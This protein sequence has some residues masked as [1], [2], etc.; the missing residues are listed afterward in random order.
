[1][2]PG[3]ERDDDWV[4]IPDDTKRFQNTHLPLGQILF[5]QST[6][7]DN[8]RNG[9]KLS[10]TIEKLQNCRKFMY[11]LPRISVVKHDG[12]NV[13]MDNRRLYCLQMAFA[14]NTLATCQES[15]PFDV[16]L[17]MSTGQHVST[18][19]CGRK[20]DDTGHSHQNTSRKSRFTQNPMSVGDTNLAW[21]QL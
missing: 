7:A 1:M 15:L 6:I 9:T 4:L 11:D 21:A 12:R 13:S 14:D 20:G 8:F 5:S 3:G 17:C 10:E 18:F 19:V 16:I 2:T